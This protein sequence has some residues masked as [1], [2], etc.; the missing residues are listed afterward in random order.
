M[1]KASQKTKV[2]VQLLLIAAF[3]LSACM[4]HTP[5]STLP[6]PMQTS[7][8]NRQIILDHLGKWQLSGKVGLRTSQESGSTT[9]TWIQHNKNYSI[10]LLGPLGTGGFLLHGYPGQVVLKTSDGKQFFAK[11]PELL[12]VQQWGYH[13]PVSYL[14]YWIRGLP[15]P[16]MPYQATFDHYH[17]LAELNQ[18]GWQIRFLSYMNAGIIDLPDKISMTSSFLNAKF[19][20]YR[21]ELFH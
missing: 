10:S 14:I 7:W 12:L 4:P 2:F 13:L 11:N 9:I 5:S 19:I 18:Q 3:G 6:P 17:R 8:K 15:V 20:I 1:L 21:W 16:Q